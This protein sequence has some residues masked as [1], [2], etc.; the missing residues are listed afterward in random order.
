MYKHAEFSYSLGLIGNIYI[1]SAKGTTLNIFTARQL[2]CGK[3]PVYIFN[4]EEFQPMVS[5]VIAVDYYS[6]R[7]GSEKY[8]R[9]EQ[10]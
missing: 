2:L 4:N 3:N 10:K 6:L 5:I 9:I 8:E 1:P 7:L